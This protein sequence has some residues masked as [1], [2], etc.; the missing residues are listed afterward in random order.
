MDYNPD[1]PKKRKDG[2][3][4]AIFLVA[5]AMLVLGSVK[6]PMFPGSLVNLLLLKH[7]KTWNNPPN[8]LHVFRVF[9]QVLFSISTLPC[10][11]KNETNAF[12]WQDAMCPTNPGTSKLDPDPWTYTGST[13]RPLEGSHD[14]ERVKPQVLCRS[15]P[16]RTMGRSDTSRHPET[17][18][19]YGVRKLRCVATRTD[20]KR[21]RQLYVSWTVST[22][23]TGVSTV[24]WGEMLGNIGKTPLKIRTESPKKECIFQP[25]IFRCFIGF[26]KGIQMIDTCSK[27][28]TST[29][30]S[31]A[32]FSK[33][34]GYVLQNNNSVLLDHK[35]EWVK[36]KLCDIIVDS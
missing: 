29:T 5:M 30:K 15:E 35:K 20:L 6:Y 18:K 8:K 28:K 25:P 1:F 14:S 19:N 24:I 9:D 32:M 34:K 2:L 12:G 3:P 10:F 17:S 27:S 36:C 22:G 7:P 13:P 21:R 16:L 23:R 11:S 31:S 4:T 33:A 26:R